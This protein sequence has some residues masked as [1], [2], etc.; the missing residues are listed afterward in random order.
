VPTECV[1]LSE[2]LAS[3]H[4]QPDC[5][6]R[7][8]FQQVQSPLD[9]APV[10]EV[11]RTVIGINYDLARPFDLKRYWKVQYHDDKNE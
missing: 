2:L 10:Y 11:Y 7:K 6:R 8:L 4:L 1:G 5:N 9:L 3:Q